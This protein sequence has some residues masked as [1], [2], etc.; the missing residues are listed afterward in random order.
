MWEA[1]DT[2]LLFFDG[3]NEKQSQTYS[4]KSDLA[5]ELKFLG[6]FSS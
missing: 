6:T 4:G 5:I 1:E 3:K 2:I